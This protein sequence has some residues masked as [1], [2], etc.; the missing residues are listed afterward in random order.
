[1]IMGLQ[2][3]HSSLIDRIGVP[4]TIL[5]NAGNISDKC[6]LVPNKPASKPFLLE[7]QKNAFF[8]WDS[9]IVDG[10]IFQDLLTEER[11][12]IAFCNFFG[13]DAI[14]AGKLALVYKTNNQ[15][16]LYQII[17]NTENTFG[18]KVYNESVKLVDYATVSYY[19]K[20][21]T[22]T[23]IGEIG[24]D[25]LFVLFSARNLGGYVP[26]TGDRIVLLNG[27]KL[28]IDGVDP[29]LYLGSYDTICSPDQ[30][31]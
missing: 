16:I 7:Y 26:Q 27:R 24:Y 18:R 10:D 19:V 20:G 30:R 29:H 22:D 31:I 8:K 5:R 15:I 12:I 17:E 13:I 6:R 28:Q 9:P 3:N 25:K 11:Y 23:P 1:M 2:D 14:K 21:D 4:I